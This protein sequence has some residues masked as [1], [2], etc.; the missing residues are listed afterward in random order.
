MIGAMKRSAQT[1]S[2][3]PVI[4][5]VLEYLCANP[6]AKDTAEG[7]ANWWVGGHGVMVDPGGV[8]TALQYLVARDWLVVTGSISYQQ[9]YGLNPTRRTELQQLFQSSK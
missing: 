1:P 3:N 9:I 2:S 8:K 7:I 6:D 4:W 5:L